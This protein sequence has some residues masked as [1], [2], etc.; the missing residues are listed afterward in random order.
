MIGTSVTKLSKLLA[1]LGFRPALYVQ[2]RCTIADLIPPDRR[3]GIYVLHFADGEVYVGQAVDVTRRF[4]QHA[5][6]H[7]DVNGVSF[8][9]A[10][11]A[12]LDERERVAVHTLEGN[13]YRVRNIVLASAPSFESD[14]DQ[15]M[16]EQDQQRWLGDLSF[17]DRSGPRVVSPELRRKYGRKFERFRSIPGCEVVMDLLRQYVQTGIPVYRK[18]EVS[19]WAVSCL[20]SFRDLNGAVLARVNIYQQEVMNVWTDQDGMKV[21]IN[22]A[23]TAL[24]ERYGQSLRSFFRTYP[25]VRD[26]DCLYKPGGHDQVRLA[27]AGVDRAAA[28]LTDE[29]VL[30]GIRTFNLRL[31]R[32][33]TTL[34]GR[35]HCF[36]L[37]DRLV[38]DAGTE[39][40]PTLDG[41][42]NQAL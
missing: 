34:F 1:T 12:E 16:P 6:I 38:D 28:L 40:P 26:D 23:R 19:F 20:P 9:H 27:V 31:M 5:R 30:K 11:A 8:A 15:V 42:Q 37:A 41:R 13:G 35:F 4:S 25:L 3:C 2:G 32:K 24:T 7:C 10:A 14:F 17:A 22:L 29:A 18:S 36:N 33:G 21:H 39:T